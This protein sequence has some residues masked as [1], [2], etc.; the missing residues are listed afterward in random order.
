MVAHEFA[1]PVGL[2][3]K[4]L[5]AGLSWEQRLEQTAALGYDSLDISVDETESRLSRLDWPPA[6]RSELRRIIEDSG[7]PILTMC[8][9][10]HRK[11]PLGSHSP[12]LRDQDFQTLIPQLRRVAAGS[13]F[14]NPSQGHCFRQ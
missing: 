4:A 2:Y 9:S 14:G 8:L 1:M 12:E 13:G 10:A 5:P 3:E 6:R 7:V 11:Y